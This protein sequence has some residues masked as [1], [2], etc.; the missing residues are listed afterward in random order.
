MNLQII[1]GSIRDGRAAK[2]VGEWAYRAASRRD[3]WHVELIDLKEWN[4][5]LL[6]F[7]KPPIMGDY[8]DPLQQQWAAKVAQRDGYLF[9]SPEYNHGYSPAL[10]NALD[11]IYHEWARKPASFISYG[12]VE[13][14]RGIEQLRLVL[15]ELQMTP[16]RDALHIQSTQDKLENCRFIA[17][18]VD[19]EHLNRVLDELIWWGGALRK[20]RGGL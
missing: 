9:I 19:E 5:P 12:S 15:I 4:L 20:A 13:G 14:A 6:N 17:D 2:P 11:Y 8:E 16:L 18:N 1:I 3:N 10:K 7:F